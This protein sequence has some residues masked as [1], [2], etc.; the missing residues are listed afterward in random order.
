MY[1]NKR[2]RVGS[3]EVGKQAGLVIINDNIAEN[4]SAIRNMETVF[5]NGVGYNSTALFDNTK[6]VVGLH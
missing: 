1:L 6:S 4:V 5:K 2:N 3:I